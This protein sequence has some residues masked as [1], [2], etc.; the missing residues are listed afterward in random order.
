MNHDTSAYET[1]RDSL[2]AQGLSIEGWAAQIMRWSQAMGRPV[3]DAPY[4]MSAEHRHFRFSLF[5]EE[6]HEYED[7]LKAMDRAGT[8]ERWKAA[9]TEVA[10]GIADQIFLL[11][12]DAAELGMGHVMDRV[13]QR[14]IDA[15]MAKLGADGKPIVNRCEAQEMQVTGNCGDDFCC[16]PA[17]LTR[18]DLP[19]GKILK[20][21]GWQSPDADIRKILFPEG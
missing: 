21:E 4:S 8:E 11:L 12:G 13:V 6:R 5:I 7:A 19:P 3:P 18:G 20:P 16:F 10:D 14:V 17:C 2:K 9:A 1:V 15:N